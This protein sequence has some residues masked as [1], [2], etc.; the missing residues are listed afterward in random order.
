MNF[1]QSKMELFKII[2][3]LFLSQILIFSLILVTNDRVQMVEA[4]KS[5][6]GGKLII[7]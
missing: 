2:L 6:G 5:K 3:N 4:M 1:A 7:S